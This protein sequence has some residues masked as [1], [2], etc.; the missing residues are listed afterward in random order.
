MNTPTTPNNIIAM[1]FLK[2]SFFFTWNLTIN[3]K[4]CHHRTLSKV[5]H[6][7]QASHHSS[8]HQH[9]LISIRPSKGADKN[10]L[11]SNYDRFQR[12]IWTYPALKII[13]GRR[14]MKKSSSSNFRTWELWPLLEIKT[15]TPVQSPCTIKRHDLGFQQIRSPNL[16]FIKKSDPT[17]TQ[18]SIQ[19]ACVILI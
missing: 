6:N 10:L 8:S 7:Y 3:Q 18:N 14:Y 16:W 19:T 12:E 15:I 17:E 5:Q 4:S 2:N 11:H 1:K 9:E 13:G